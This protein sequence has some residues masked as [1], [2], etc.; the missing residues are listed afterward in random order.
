MKVIYF[1][2]VGE[3]V[4]VCKRVM[5]DT[6]FWSNVI[7]VGTVPWPNATPLMDAMA[8]IK[9]DSS[10]C[11]FLIDGETLNLLCII[12]DSRRATTV[13]DLLSSAKSKKSAS[14]SGE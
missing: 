3:D 8:I 11:P 6:G 9:Q 13:M 1:F 14:K 12:D 5:E 10:R 7:D 2:R 4:T